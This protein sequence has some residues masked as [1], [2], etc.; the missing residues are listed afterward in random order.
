MHLLVSCM[1]YYHI[2]RTESSSLIDFAIGAQTSVLREARRM[3]LHSLVPDMEDMTTSLLP[4]VSHETHSKGDGPFSI[5]FYSQENFDLQWY[6]W[7]LREHQKRLAWAVVVSL[8]VQIH[9][10]LTDA[11]L[12]SKAIECRCSLLTDSSPSLKYAELDDLYLPCDETLWEA[13][14]STSWRSLFPW[15]HRPPRNAPFLGFLRQG[16]AKFIAEKLPLVSKLVTHDLI[17]LVKTKLLAQ[18]LLSRG[19]EHQRTSEDTKP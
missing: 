18:N 7:I 9:A 3:A 19:G 14:D 8:S 2:V 12:F 16:E 15:T 11:I 1:A 5:D 17:T 13:T 10:C 4:P 6:S